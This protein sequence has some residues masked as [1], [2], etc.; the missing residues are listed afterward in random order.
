MSRYMLRYMSRAHAQWPDYQALTRDFFAYTVKL[1]SKWRTGGMAPK[2]QN[3]LKVV[4]I[5]SHK[6]LSSQFLC[7]NCK[8]ATASSSLPPQSMQTEGKGGFTLPSIFLGPTVSPLPTKNEA[9]H[10]PPLNPSYLHSTSFL[11]A[12]DVASCYLEEH[13]ANNRKCL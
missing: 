5:Y 10:S 13:E 12:H 3:R 11:S 7:R 4:S 6:I 1:R 8:I 2:G 9:L